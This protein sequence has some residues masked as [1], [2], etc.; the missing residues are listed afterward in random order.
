VEKEPAVCWLTRFTVDL[1]AQPKG[2]D[3][4]GE[5]GTS[6]SPSEDD[7]DDEMA[8]GC[9]LQRTL[10]VSISVNRESTGNSLDFGLAASAGS[11]SIALYSGH[12][13]DFSSQSS[14]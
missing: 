6:I 11:A 8:M 2:Y 13:L 10:F 9:S 14:M 1:G 4:G 3:L 7:T 12:L 5:I